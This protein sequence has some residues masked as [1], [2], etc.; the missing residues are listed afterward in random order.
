MA[1][2]VN[3]SRRYGKIP[4]M[5]LSTLIFALSFITNVQELITA[6]EREEAGRTFD[7]TARLT[8]PKSANN[9]YLMMA[10]DTGAYYT[11]SSFEGMAAADPHPGDLARMQ[12]RINLKK[13]AFGNVS[14]N[15][16]CLKLSVIRRLPPLPPTETTP[17]EIASGRFDYRPVRLTGTIQD[18]SRQSVSTDWYDLMLN[19]AGETIYMTTRSPEDLTAELDALVGAEVE[20]TGV[21][22]A[23]KDAIRGIT[24]RICQIPSLADIRVLT[25]P[26][27]RFDAPTFDTTVIRTPQEIN[28]LGRVNVKGR[29]L[30]VWGRRLLALLPDGKLLGVDLM[31]D[32]LP[33]CG[34]D[35]EA[36]GFVE[37]DTYELNL[38]RAIWRPCTDAFPP[39]PA[40]VTQKLRTQDLVGD[41]RKSPQISIRWHGKPI[42]LTGTVITSSPDGLITLND[43]GHL[44][45]VDASAS[46]GTLVPPLPQSRIRVSGICVFEFEKWQPHQP[47]PRATGFILV[48]RKDA[49]IAVLQTPPWWTSQ[50]LFL[51]VLTLIAVLIAVFVWNVI[52]RRLVE[53][54]GRELLREEIGR[55]KATLRVDE[56]THLAVELHDALS[57]TLTGVALQVDAAERAR[58]KA[59]DRLAGHL[60]TARRTLEN[61]REELRNCLWD[62]RNQ[63][64]EINDINRA[65]RQTLEPHIGDAALSV[66]FALARSKLSDTTMHAVLRII[67]ELAVNAVRHGHAKSIRIAGS[68]ENGKLMFSVKDDGCGFDPENRPGIDTGHFGLHG[69]GERIASL[70]GSVDINSTVGKGTRITVSLHLTVGTGT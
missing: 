4:I 55:V 34:A 68:V 7:F 8:L 38:S 33:V 27:N 53:R 32:T 56:R 70:G 43:D 59:P 40:T 13:D 17:H 21:C 50:R 47:F 52:L 64:L 25:P 65:I 11:Y 61:C 10:D 42:V 29:V 6:V 1:T 23:D 35:I 44:V 31:T 22:H 51:L 62:L 28:R 9:P 69:I 2:P 19:C 66:R 49:D 54:R 46:V 48:P 45:R 24:G 39:F 67:R 60:A 15:A 26:R 18:A 41:G 14:C 37:T 3:F 20:V 12:G 16:D 63:A 5:L 58:Q 30:A 57:Q 36:V